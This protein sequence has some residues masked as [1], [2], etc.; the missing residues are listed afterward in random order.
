M[1]YGYMRPDPVEIFRKQ[2]AFYQ[3]LIAVAETQGFTR[4]EAI[5]ILKVAAMKE[6]EE[7]LAGIERNTY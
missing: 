5:E 2:A 3:Q 4:Q 1:P 7:A 6:V